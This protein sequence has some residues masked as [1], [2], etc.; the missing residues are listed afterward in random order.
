MDLPKASKYMNHESALLGMGATDANA[1][2]A[3]VA[4]LTPG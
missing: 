3:S 2:T 4:T 1:T